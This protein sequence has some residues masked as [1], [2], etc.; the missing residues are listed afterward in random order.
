MAEESGSGLDTVTL[1]FPPHMIISD[2][3]CS[4]LIAISTG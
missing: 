3:G 4:L 2:F 1:F